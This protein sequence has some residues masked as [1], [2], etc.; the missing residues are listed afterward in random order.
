MRFRWPHFREDRR[1]ESS[2]FGELEWIGGTREGADVR[3]NNDF[4]LLL[5]LS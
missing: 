4:R 1:V 3:T 5:R 2:G